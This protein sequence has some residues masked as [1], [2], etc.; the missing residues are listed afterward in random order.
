MLAAIWPGVRR[1]CAEKG[2]DAELVVVGDGPYRE[3]MQRELQGQGVVF[4]G[5]RRGT[6]LAALYASSDLFAFP[7]TTDTL[8]QVVL[9]SQAS[10]LP[11]IVTDQG[12]PKEVVD[13]AISGLV[14]P[15]TDRGAWSDAL[16]RL[17]TDTETRERMGRSAQTRAT[18]YSIAASF[19]Q[20]WSVHE[21]ANRRD[22]IANGHSPASKR[23]RSIGAP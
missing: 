23:S 8:G 20:F 19:E 13:H 18:R 4:T 12:G 1:A 3:R 22:A 6:E 9:E 17:A 10:G 16:V 11:V 2:V 15:A 14:I 21:E 7:S 5:I